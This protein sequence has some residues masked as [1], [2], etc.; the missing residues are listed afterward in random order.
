MY[1]ENTNIGYDSEMVQKKQKLSV[2]YQILGAI[3][4]ITGCLFKPFYNPFLMEAGSVFSYLL[5][6]ELWIILLMLTIIVTACVQEPGLSLISVLLGAGVAGY[7]FYV[8]YNSKGRLCVGVGYYIMLAGFLVIMAGIV[9]AVWNRKRVNRNIKIAISFIVVLALVG[10]GYATG[11][12]MYQREKQYQDAK[13]QM[14]A[15]SYENALVN[16]AIV[17]DYRKAKEK[18]R[19]CTY[20]LGSQYAG[21]GEYKNAKILLDR[22]G[23]YQ[24][25]KEQ[26]TLCEF[27]ILL[28]ETKGEDM[29]ERITKLMEF[30]GY[31]DKETECAKLAKKE[32]DRLLKKAKY[33]KAI[34]FLDQV[35]SLL[36]TE[37]LRMECYSKLAD[38]LYRKGDYEA[39]YQVIMQT[40]AGDFVLRSMIKMKLRES[41][42][43]KLGKFKDVTYRYA[44]YGGDGWAYE[45]TWNAIQGADGYDVWCYQY[46]CETPYEYMDTIIGAENNFFE[47][48]ASVPVYA[49]VMVRSFRYVDG[50][51]EV[52]DWSKKVT[53]YL[54]Y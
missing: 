1:C 29:A 48:Q 2:F 23:D 7:R 39:A 9:L 37:E 4:V 41:R 35:S 46:S 3:L 6:D 16:F 11:S 25:A 30:E 31:K 33:D 52:S 21:V 28:E 32:V 14:N 34:V 43:P 44:G 53:G 13:K 8:C 22:V 50:E 12:K 10:A 27:Q 5:G 49:E 15:D 20:K 54:D 47:I 38:A 36:E 40:G 18:K 42:I 17:G 24:D 45:V 51:K 19:E 26:L